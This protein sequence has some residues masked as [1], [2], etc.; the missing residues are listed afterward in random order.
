MWWAVV[1]TGCELEGKSV[2]EGETMSL[3]TDPC[4]TCTCMVTF[5]SV[6]SRP[7]HTTSTYGPD[8][9]VVCTGLKFSHLQ[10]YVLDITPVTS[11]GR[12]DVSER[13]DISFCTGQ[14]RSSECSEN[15]NRIQFGRPLQFH[16]STIKYLLPLELH[17]H[18]TVSNVTLTSIILSH[19]IRL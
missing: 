13:L 17:H 2:E 9:R 15:E 10:C 7:V 18:S 12:R 19:S 3:T 11:C 14:S 4:T 1:V 8:V 5:T 16:K 6:V